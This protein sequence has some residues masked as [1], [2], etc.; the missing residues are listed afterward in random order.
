M[1]GTRGKPSCTLDLLNHV[2]DVDAASHLLDDRTRFVRVGHLHR[3][4]DCGFA[5][6][7][8]RVL[9]PGQRIT[10]GASHIA[11]QPSSRLPLQGQAAV[12]L[13]CPLARGDVARA[14]L[15]LIPCASRNRVRCAT[16]R[17]LVSETHTVLEFGGGGVVLTCVR[18][19]GSLYTF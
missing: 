10:S 9:G 7:G 13:T 4:A 5:T 19:A 3:G 15:L 6:V 2:V 14:L 1:V 8:H 11:V 16:T 12:S 17:V 18:I